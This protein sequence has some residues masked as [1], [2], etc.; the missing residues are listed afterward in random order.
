MFKVLSIL[1]SVT[2]VLAL[3]VP[4]AFGGD[5]AHPQDA[6]GGN[7][8]VQREHPDP[9]RVSR[10]GSEREDSDRSDDDDEFEGNERSRHH[11][12]HHHHHDHDGE[13]EGGDR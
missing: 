7:D 12:R 5:S 8:S 10:G 13:G 9:L 4:S 2:L 1:S 3:G 6:S 11:H